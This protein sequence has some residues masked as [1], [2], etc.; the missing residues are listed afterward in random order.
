MN[1][2]LVLYVLA[3][4]ALCVGLLVRAVYR[5]RWWWMRGVTARR[6]AADQ[7]RLTP[8]AV[9]KH[10]NASAHLTRDIDRPDWQR[11][12]GAVQRCGRALT[13]PGQEGAGTLAAAAFQIADTVIQQSATLPVSGRGESGAGDVLSC[14]ATDLRR[15]MYLNST[16]STPS[17]WVVKG[18]KQP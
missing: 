12:Q 14:A 6:A 11:Y 3:P 9:V 16:A 15:A 2:E 8:A 10:L 1:E 4:A 18:S 17:V 13:Q 5:S 7:D